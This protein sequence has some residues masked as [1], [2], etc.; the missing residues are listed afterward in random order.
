[1]RITRINLVKRRTLIMIH[2]IIDRGVIAEVEKTELEVRA[3][4]RCPGV[5]LAEPYLESLAVVAVEE[6]IVL[7]NTYPDQSPKPYV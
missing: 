6:T 5:A 2:M 7:K 1:M 3:A 4:Q